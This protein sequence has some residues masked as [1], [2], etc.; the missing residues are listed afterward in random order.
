LRYDGGPCFRAD[1]YQAEIDHLASR[2][3]AYH[4][5]HKT[6]GYVEMFIQT[7]KQQVLWIERFDTLEEPAHSHQLLRRELQR[8]RL[9]ERLPPNA[10]HAKRFVAPPITM[11]AAST[12]QAPVNQGSRN[13]VCAISHVGGAATWEGCRHESSLL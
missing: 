12:K 13:D 2:S 1:H 7:L 5:E 11:I 8:A 10:K 9:L 4:H 3:P 6:N